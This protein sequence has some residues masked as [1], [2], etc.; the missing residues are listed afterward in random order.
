MT[1]PSP[2]V[3]GERLFL[4]LFTEAD[5]TA[6][7]MKWLNDPEVVRFSNQRLL[8]H[9]DQSCLAYLRTFSG[10]DD[11]FLAIRLAS[12]GRLIGTMTAYVSLHHGTADMG[13]LIGEQALWGQGLGLEAWRLLMDYLFQTR[14]LRKITG[15][16]LRGNVGMVRIMERSGMHLEAARMRQEIVEG[17]PQDVVYFAKFRTN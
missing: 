11:L 4:C 12:D 17:E 15:G 8:H 13:L 2:L 14:K 10:G 16:A 5:I 6:D 3:S 7:Y 9:D 1:W